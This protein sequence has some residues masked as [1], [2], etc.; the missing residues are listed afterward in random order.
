MRAA[1]LSCH[2]PFPSN[3]AIEPFPFARRI[4][5]DPARSRYWVVCTKCGK[6]SLAP[7]EAGE[8]ASV[9]DQLERWWRSSSARYTTDDI[10][11]GQYNPKL[12]VVR[13]GEANWNQFAAWRYGKT[14]RWRRYRQFGTSSLTIAATTAAAQFGA[15]A[16]GQAFVV[17]AVV[18]IP[19]YLWPN[20]VWSFNRG[21]ICKVPGTNGKRPTLRLRDLNH[22]ELVRDSSS[23]WSLNTSHDGGA[24]TF[25]GSQAVRLLSYVLPKLNF[26]GATRRAL[27]DALTVIDQAGGPEGVIARAATPVGRRAD[28]SGDSLVLARQASAVRIALEMS[29]HE[30]VE[31]RALDNELTLLHREWR[32]AEEIAGIV[33][34]LETTKATDR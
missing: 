15:I 1:C 27:G 3:D 26:L 5:Y 31:R 4:A 13:I 17:L 8:R 11:L 16:F 20:S 24:S 28:K 22:V 23:S 25:A 30:D 19:L 12:S 7:I 2:K 32:E 33:V 9:I 34:Q 14:L 18:L 29:T 10:G 21:P 6:W